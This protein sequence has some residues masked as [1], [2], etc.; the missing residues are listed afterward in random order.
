M[1]GKEFKVVSFSIAENDKSGNTKFINCL[2]YNDKIKDLRNLKEGYFDQLSGKKKKSLYS[3][4][5]REF[6]IF[7]Y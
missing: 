3:F 6:I 2:V 4:K 5:T 7:H 1:I